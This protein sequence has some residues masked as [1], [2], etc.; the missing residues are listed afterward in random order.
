MQL[1]EFYEENVGRMFCGILS[2]FHEMQI[3]TLE[4]G[5]R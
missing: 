4:K 2:D 1:K 5:T 3:I